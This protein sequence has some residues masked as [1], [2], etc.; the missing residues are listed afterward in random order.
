M[1]DN[2]DCLYEAN[3]VGLG[4]TNHKVIGDLYQEAV[5]N[6]DKEFILK[7]DRMIIR[8]YSLNIITSKVEFTDYIVDPES[9]VALGCD[10]ATNSDITY[11]NGEFVCVD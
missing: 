10:Q 4:V 8:E 2:I 1:L 6:E 3:T 5:M 9:V 11:I 7:N